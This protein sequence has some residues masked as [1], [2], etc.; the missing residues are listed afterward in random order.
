M[1]CYITFLVVSTNSYDMLLGYDFLRKM[2]TV[3]D[4]EQSL[5]QIRRRP[6]EDKQVLPLNE[7]HRLTPLEPR[8][9]PSERVRVQSTCRL[10][11]TSEGILCVEVSIEGKQIMARIDSGSSVTVCSLGAVRRLGLMEHMM[12]GGEYCTASGTIED[13]A[14]NIPTL[15]MH[16]WD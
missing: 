12:D 2:G 3:V 4:F 10:G 9:E 13:A 1:S 14:G 7:I 5:I 6:G 11:C 8:C 16:R 15:C